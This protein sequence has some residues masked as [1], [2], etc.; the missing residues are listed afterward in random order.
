MDNHSVSSTPLSGYA[1]A[2]LRADDPHITVRLGK[3]EG[4]CNA[5]AHVYFQGGKRPPNAPNPSY[6]CCGLYPAHLI[7]PGSQAQPWRDTTDT[8]PQ[9][10][11]FPPKMSQKMRKKLN[12]ETRNSTKT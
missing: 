10:V 1:Q 3:S 5:T 2:P 7:P 11:I 9:F 12:D 6:V 4:W 8:A